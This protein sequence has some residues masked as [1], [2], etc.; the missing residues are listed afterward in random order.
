VSVP[1][2]SIVSC[3]F[4]II[5][6]LAANRNSP[7]LCVPSPASLLQ[8]K[9][10]QFLGTKEIN[11][12]VCGGLRIV[13]ATSACSIFV[14]EIRHHRVSVLFMIRATQVKVS[15]GRG[16]TGLV[17]LCVPGSQS[18]SKRHGTL[19]EGTGRAYSNNGRA[20]VGF[21]QVV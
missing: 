15:W 20:S 5:A 17:A 18:C 4:F 11:E 7:R 13:R 9:C 21:E 6:N 12:N 10:L 19:P 2:H 16:G 1:L 8:I 3:A 14:S